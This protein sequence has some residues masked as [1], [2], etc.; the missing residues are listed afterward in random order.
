M[1]D[2]NVWNTQ[3]KN[4]HNKRFYETSPFVVEYYGLLMFINTK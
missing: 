2:K 4:N 1:Q 3:I